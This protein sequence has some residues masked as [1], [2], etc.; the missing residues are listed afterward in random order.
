MNIKPVVRK[1]IRYRSYKSFIETDFNFGLSC[2]PF[3]IMDIFDDIDD[4]YWTFYKMLINVV[5]CHAPI[6]TKKARLSEAPFLTPELKKQSEKRKC[7][8]IN[9]K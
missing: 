5:D 7:F 2:I 1:Y 4:K 9:L 6:K 3:H 8:G